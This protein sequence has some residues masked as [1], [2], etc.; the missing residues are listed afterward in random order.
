MEF[1]RDRQ[2]KSSYADAVLPSTDTFFAFDGTNSDLA[3][4]LYF[5]AKANQSADQFESLILPPTIKDRLDDLHLQ[6]DLLPGI[7]QRALLWD[8]G[9]AVTPENIVVQIWTLGGYSITD[10]AIPLT[11]FQ[12]V[13][14]VEMNCTQ[15]DNSTAYSN[16]QCTGDQ[17]LRAARCVVEDF[18]DSSD[19]HLA[20][21]MTGG[22]PVV[23]PTPRVAK[24]IW[25]DKSNN[26]S[27]SV[28]AI[29]TLDLD[30]EQT[31][32]ECAADQ[33]GGYGSLVLPCHTTAD[34][35]T[36]MTNEKQEVQGSPWVSRWLVEDYA[37][38]ASVTSASGHGFNVSLFVP[39]ILVAGIA[40]AL[41]GLFAYRKRRQHEDDHNADME[42][43]MFYENNFIPPVFKDTNTPE[44]TSAQDR[45][46]PPTTNEA[47]LASRAYLD[48]INARRA[49][50]SSFMSDTSAAESNFTLRTL[51]WSE[52]LVDKRIPYENIVFERK[53]SKGASG[54]VWRCQYMGQHVAVKRL[55][56]SK[57]HRAEEVKHFAKEIELNAS[58]NHPHIVSFIGVAWNS[59]D[60]LVMVLEFFPMGDLKTYL[61]KN[62]D[63][64]TWAGDKTRIAA[65]IGRALEYLHSR[66]PPLIHRDVKSKNILLTM[67]LEAKLIDFGVSTNCQDNAM[68]AGVGTPY[69]TAPEVLEGKRY[70]QQ[71][72]IYSFGVVLSELDTCEAPYHD[73]MSVDGK[74]LKP[75]QLLS[76]VMQGTLRPSFSEDCPQ[77][78]RRLAISCCQHD[79]DKRPS[80]S[81]VVATL[82]A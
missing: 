66:T 23:I 49:S 34:I 44:D 65:G 38:V 1:H 12:A 80:A 78:I 53:L 71:A 11:Q 62:V 48:L 58:L 18:D 59:L 13:G 2:L 43:L 29:H 35:S 42:D 3:R 40:T 4:Q 26:V 72:D 17:M 68:T 25:K 47:M 10:L 30:V 39:I 69:W 31:Y 46:T 19:P 28:S 67:M 9:F 77:Q 8:S 64:L 61:H 60:N 7:A 33:N 16:N 45:S 56:R 6:W 54:E 5:R 20:M 76:E 52:F 32:H 81:Q 15:P 24:H 14:C 37:N 82:E 70:T 79:P 57:N 51:L 75:F 21:W 50:S 41:I 22:N 36:S 55:L 74:K 63:L 73:A 27:Y